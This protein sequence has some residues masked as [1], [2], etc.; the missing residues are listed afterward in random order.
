MGDHV[1]FVSIFANGVIL[2]LTEPDIIFTISYH[3]AII[4]P[5]VEAVPQVLRCNWHK[6]L[7]G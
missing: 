5:Q 2:F 4:K 6:S 1:I 7:P 3:I